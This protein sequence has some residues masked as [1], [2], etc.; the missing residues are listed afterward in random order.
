MM[1]SG[2]RSSSSINVSED[3]EDG[4][5]IDGGDVA[6]AGVYSNGKVVRMSEAGIR[7][8][9][10]SDA[11]KSRSPIGVKVHTS[12][13]R[14][15]FVCERTAGGQTC[16]SVGMNGTKCNPEGVPTFDDDDLTVDDGNRE[17]AVLHHR[18]LSAEVL[19]EMYK[20]RKRPLERGNT[21]G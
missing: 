17:R 1:D 18:L 12:S 3:A 13:N 4:R 21:L 11:M 19:Q 9:G 14:S 16:L 10:K 2:D 6:V 7:A 5:P 8:F 20:M 15:R